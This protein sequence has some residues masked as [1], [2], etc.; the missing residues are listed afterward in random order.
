MNSGI[1]K[2]SWK[3]TI[4]TKDESLFTETSDD[5]MY[6]LSEFIITSIND[7]CIVGILMALLNILFLD[8]LLSNADNIAYTLYGYLYPLV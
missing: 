6:S 3:S 2:F 1:W 4:S 5:S 8:M 7:V